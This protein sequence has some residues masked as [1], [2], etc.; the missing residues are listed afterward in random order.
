M[1][2]SRAS[3]PRFAAA[4]ARRGVA[5]PRARHRP[6]ATNT[7]A[8]V[9]ADASRGPLGPW[10]SPGRVGHLHVRL[11]PTRASFPPTAL[12][13]AVFVYPAMCLWT[14]VSTSISAA[15]HG[16]A[17][18]SA[19]CDPRL[20]PA[21]PVARRGGPPGLVDLAIALA[22]T[23]ILLFAY[24]IYPGSAAPPAPGLDRRRGRAA[25]GLGQLLAAVNVKYRDV[26]IRPAVPPADLVLPEPDGVPVVTRRAINGGC[27]TRSTRSWPRRRAALEPRRRAA[28]PARGPRVARDAVVYR[29]RGP[30]LLPRRSRRTSPT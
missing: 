30:V 29:H 15:A 10:S 13:Y 16:A 2:R 4:R 17:A 8:P 19:P 5:L 20:L 27:S 25:F 3:P 26:R 23:A 24:E 21:H 28:A 14:Y 12:P 18:E 11:R 22:L 6:R 9:P 1:D 7:E